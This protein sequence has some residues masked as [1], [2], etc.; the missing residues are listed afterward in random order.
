MDNIEPVPPS[1]P[2]QKTTI[3]TVRKISNPLTLISIFSAISEVAIVGVLPILG[4][5]IQGIFV[6]F[7]M[8]FPFVI[9]LCFFLTLNFNHRVLY[10]PSDYNDDDAFLIA[11]NI[12]A[13]TLAS[14]AGDQL[15][16]AQEKL[17]EVGALITDSKTAAEVKELGEAVKTATDEVT[18]AK[19]YVDRI[20]SMDLITVGD[21][22]FLRKCI[23]NG[24][25]FT[26]TDMLKGI[27][28]AYE[29][30]RSKESFSR[31]IRHGYIIISPKSVGH[32]KHATYEVTELGI[33]KCNEFDSNIASIVQGPDLTQIF[34]HDS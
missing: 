8:S 27:S 32:R 7:A 33:A 20:K 4:P 23:E 28:S 17:E 34:R 14:E 9:V 26:V 21:L 29:L 25:E 1:L 22:A 16:A 3:S 30:D 15:H 31:L 24:R 2:K 19:R 12:S 13:A 11:A 5:E 6:W 18:T 10:A